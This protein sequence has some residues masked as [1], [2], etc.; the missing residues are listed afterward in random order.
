MGAVRC[1]DSRDDV[2]YERLLSEKTDGRGW[3]GVFKTEPRII[4]GSATLQQE[5]G[6]GGFKIIFVRV[7]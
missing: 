1:I 5:G 3:Q 6:G 4:S 2:P 7:G